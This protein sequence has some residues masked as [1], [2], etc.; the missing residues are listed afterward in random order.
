M[1]GYETE[2]IRRRSYFNYIHPDDSYIVR[3]VWSHGLQTNGIAMSYRA[4]LQVHGGGVWI[5]CE[6]VATV[7]ENSVVVCTSVPSGEEKRIG[8]QPNCSQC[9]PF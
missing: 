5:G 1:L 6:H 8:K 2:D 9:I 4:R 3:R 7:L